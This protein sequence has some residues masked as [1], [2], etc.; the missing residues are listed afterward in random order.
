MSNS[1]S[2]MVFSQTVEIAAV[3]KFDALFLKLSK[4][5]DKHR[6][7]KPKKGEILAKVMK[8]G[9]E[10]VTVESVFS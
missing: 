6:L 4:H 10:L 1:T 5:A 7:K 9:A 8:A 3:K 2:T